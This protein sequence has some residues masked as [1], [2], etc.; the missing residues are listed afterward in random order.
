MIRYLIK[1][2]GLTALG[3]CLIA[4]SIPLTSTIEANTKA[5]RE[6]RN[7]ITAATDCRTAVADLMKTAMRVK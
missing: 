6:S 4:V 3:L 7:A 2:F 1:N 5:L